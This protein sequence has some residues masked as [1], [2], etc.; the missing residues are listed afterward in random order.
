MPESQIQFGSK[1]GG[2]QIQ[3]TVGRLASLVAGAVRTFMHV[4]Y[5]R[6]ERFTGSTPIHDRRQKDSGNLILT[7]ASM[8][9]TPTGAS[10]T[11]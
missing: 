4:V 11:E 1:T 10:R 2:G 7:I 8:I 3:I 9:G 5:I 6:Y